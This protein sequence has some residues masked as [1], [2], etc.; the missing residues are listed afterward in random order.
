MDEVEIIK[1]IGSM[2]VSFFKNNQQVSRMIKPNF[3]LQHEGYERQWNTFRKA[4][5]SQT[6]TTRTIV[7][8]SFPIRG[9]W[10]RS[11]NSD[12]NGSET[13]GEMTVCSWVR[14]ISDSS[15]QSMAQFFQEI[16]SDI[17][18]MTDVD[19]VASV[20]QYDQGTEGRGNFQ[21]VVEEIGKHKK[22][23]VFE[24]CMKKQILRDQVMSWTKPVVK[25]QTNV[26]SSIYQEQFLSR[27]TPK[28][29]TFSEKTRITRKWW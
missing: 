18:S 16:L 23:Q 15:S 2:L 17:K 19:I 22:E 9:F 29:V 14:V 21:Q 7:P 11:P 20:I 4:S 26:Q 8:F 1:R 10:Y 6:C 24:N 27:L 28:V 12:P 3:I 13:A 25:R 5:G